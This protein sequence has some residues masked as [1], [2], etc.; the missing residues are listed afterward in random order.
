MHFLGYR[1]TKLPHGQ[2]VDGHE[3][4]DV[5]QYRQEVYIPIYQQHAQKMRTWDND[6]NETSPLL[7][8]GEKYTVLWFHDE[9][10]F[11][12]NDRREVFWIHETETAVPKPKGEGASL[13]VSAFVSAD[14][15]F[16]HAP[17]GS[18]TALDYFHAGKNQDG[19][20]KNEDIC[21]Q[22]MRAARITKNYYPQDNHVF[23][24]DNATTHKKR[25]DNAL[26]ARNMPK[27]S[28]K[29]G[30]K[31]FGVDIPVLGDD[32]KPLCDASGKVQK[33]RV[34][35]EMAKLDDGTPQSLYFDDGRFKGMEVI[36]QERGYDG[37]QKKP[38]AKALLAQCNKFKC[39]PGRTDCCC[40][41]LLYTQPDF[42]NVP[43]RLE[44]DLSLQGIQVL[45]LPKFHCELNALE[46]CWCHSKRVYRSYPRDS[47]E[48]ALMENVKAALDSIP[49]LS[50]RR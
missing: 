15:G 44:R 13:M 6:G 27:A 5:V 37:I 4:E 14:Y 42:Q 49:L 48:K 25:P 8:E 20:Y 31:P 24:Y 35:M 16:L 11:Y 47:S 34:Q 2:Y 21:S 28:T 30:S 7:G 29:P 38:D 17:D 40:R 43:S 22:A 45:F 33:T 12:A 32:G 18:E 19:Y 23:V 50:I 1:W 26:C 10:T 3:R 46:Q 36:L 41:R 9:S 39:P